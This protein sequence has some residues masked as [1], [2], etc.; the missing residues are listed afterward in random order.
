MSETNDKQ[1]KPECPY[2]ITL[3]KQPANELRLKPDKKKRT[4]DKGASGQ[5]F[6]LSVTL[7]SLANERY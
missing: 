3:P 2:C 7:L 1:R 5:F 4:L 6:F